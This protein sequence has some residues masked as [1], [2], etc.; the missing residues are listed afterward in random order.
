MCCGQDMRF[1][2]P[3]GYE[4]DAT[5]QALLGEYVAIEVN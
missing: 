5:N 3:P 1:H 2:L 4:K